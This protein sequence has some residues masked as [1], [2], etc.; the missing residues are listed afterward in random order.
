MDDHSGTFMV[1]FSG[2]R[3]SG[4]WMVPFDSL[5]TFDQL[6]MALGGLFV[7]MW[8]SPGGVATPVAGVHID[9]RTADVICHLID[10]WMMGFVTS[11]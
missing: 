7:V 6:S 5:C 9:S 3:V 8:S 2:L 1:F 4:F 10:R 11:S